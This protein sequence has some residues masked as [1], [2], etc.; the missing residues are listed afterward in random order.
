MPFEPHRDLILPPDATILWRYMDFAK[1]IH[2][3]ERQSLWFSRADQ[4]EDP[5]EGTYTDAEIEHLR[6]FDANN[7]VPALRVSDRH[8]RGP[9]YMRTTA[10]VSC[11]RAGAGES[12]AMWDLMARAAA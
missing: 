5:L 12:L 11:W 4:F 3:L 6:S 9:K 10:Y 8:L 7:A 1:F 2:F